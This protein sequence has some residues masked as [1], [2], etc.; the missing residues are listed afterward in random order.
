MK[1]RTVDISS[2]ASASSIVFASLRRAIIEGELEDGAPLRQDAI[3]ALFNTSRIP[4]REALSR[5]E[6]QGL[7]ETRRYRGAVVA[8]LSAKEAA[9]IFDFL[10]LLESEVIATAVPRLSAASLLE[11]RRQYEAFRD[12]RD[13]YE[14]GELNRGFHYALYRDSGLDYHLRAIDNALDRVERYLRTQLIATDGHDRANR[15]HLQILT[16]CE[17][18]N[19]ARAAYLTRRHI[20]GAKDTLLEFLDRPGSASAG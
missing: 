17:Q 6:Q 16:A 9:E 15:E 3:A 18:G 13:P 11:V 2:T 4:V 14:W 1:I 8:R 20:D 19:A 12:S 7:V 5:L 10:S